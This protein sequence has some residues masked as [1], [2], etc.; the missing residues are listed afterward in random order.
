[1]LQETLRSTGHHTRLL[2]AK[3]W[4]YEC[5][6]EAGQYSFA[7]RGFIGTR[8][9]TNRNT[10]IYLEATGLLAICFLR[11]DKLDQAK[12]LV[13][14]ALD[15]VRNIKSERKRQQFHSR[16]LLRLEEECVL[17]GL[18]SD[19][20]ITMNEQ[21]AIQLALELESSNKTEEQLL[22]ELGRALPPKALHLAEEVR[23]IFENRLPAPERL[24]LP[25]P[26]SEEDLQEVGKRSE[27]ALKRV[28]WRAL[29]DP[30]SELHQKWTAAND[31]FFDKKVLMG[32]LGAACIKVSIFPGVIIL[33][34]VVALAIRFGA[35][36]FCEKY[37]PVG[38]MIEQKDES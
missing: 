21:E 3:N 1:M 33:A 35:T 12:P 15:R 32:A 19:T 28:A 20:P 17:A 6:I 26:M 23:V 38:L 2:K 37:Q 29:C 16:F 13:R 27:S 31:V 9:L 30:K 11:R 4:L 22:I 25:P 24:A 18:H 10:R 34:A 7:E 5:A 14:E 36:V 8:K